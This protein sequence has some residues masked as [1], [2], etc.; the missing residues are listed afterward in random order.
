MKNL[1]VIVAVVIPLVTGAQ[2]N[3]N[4]YKLEGNE[5]CYKACEEANAA[6]ELYQGS[7]ASQIKFDKAIK[8]CPA[9]DYAYF[10]KAVPF[11]KN[12]QF[13]EWKKF[14][15]EAV[16]L[17]PERHLGYRGW[18]RYQF[19]RDYH[20]AIRDIEQ[21]DSMVTYDIGYSV[22]GDYH[23][24]V[25]RALC[26]KALGNPKKAIAIIEAQLAVKDYVP[27]NYDYLHLGV[28]KLETGD[29]AGAVTFL[30]KQIALNDYLA[31]TYY[32]LGLA[33]RQQ[34]DQGECVTAM[35]K[36][37]VFYLKGWKRLDFYTHPADKVYLA[38]IERELTSMR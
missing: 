3:C 36:A 29:L 27:M 34:G 31:D 35:E 22:N 4:V 25:A 8:L 28:L 1:L 16:T 10:E 17:N 33:Y 32:Y 23:L 5:A 14:I 13:I 6:A 26:Y 11:L 19:L 15:D 30:K 9:Y 24:Q 20:G 37:K 21:L 7:K 38:D 12:G 18:C 2:P